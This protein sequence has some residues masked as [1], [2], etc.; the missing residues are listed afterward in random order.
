MEADTCSKSPSAP[1]NAEVHVIVV[2]WFLQCMVY[3]PREGCMYFRGR[4]PRKYIQHEGGTYPMHCKNHETAVLDRVRLTAGL[5]LA[6]ECLHYST[7]A[8]AVQ[9]KVPYARRCSYSSIA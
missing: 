9:H 7:C 5:T 8:L 1:Q 6:L 3:V 2:S 4:S